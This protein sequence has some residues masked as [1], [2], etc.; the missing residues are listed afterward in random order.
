MK[1]MFIALFLFSCAMLVSFKSTSLCATE[2]KAFDLFD[3]QCRA[4]QNNFYFVVDL[5]EGMDKSPGFIVIGPPGDAIK[6]I[7]KL[8]PVQGH[9]IIDSEG[10]TI[11]GVRIAVE[12][13]NAETQYDLNYKISE[14]TDSLK[15]SKEIKTLKEVEGSASNN[16]FIDIEKDPIVKIF[17]GKGERSELIFSFPLKKKFF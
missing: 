17:R 15:I 1:K 2:K 7:F 9:E 10:N 13:R 4:D 3:Y 14:M 8:V 11:T 5:I 6:I 16:A 12:L